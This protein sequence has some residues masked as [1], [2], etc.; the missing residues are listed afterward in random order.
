MMIYKNMVCNIPPV[1]RIFVVVLSLLL[2]LI[3]TN[4]SLAQPELHGRSSIDDT[5]VSIAD[6][7]DL[8][9]EQIADAAMNMA[10]EYP[11]EYNI[12]QVCEIYNSL[13]G[14]EGWYYFSDPSNADHYQNANKTLQMGKKQNTVGMGNCNDFSI[15]MASL[16]DSI[17]GSTR[18]IFAYDGQTGINHA[19]T[20]LYIGKAGDDSVNATLQFLEREYYPEKISGIEYVGDEVWLNL[21]WGTDPARA[22]NP[23]GA[24]FAEGNSD[25][26]KIVVWQSDSRARPGIVSVIEN[27]DSIE[28]WQTIADDLGSAIKIASEPGEKGNGIEV[29][30][31]LE[32]GGWVAIY[33]QIDPAA[34][35][36]SIGLMIS[37]FNID[38][39]DVLKLKL[40]YDD[41]TAFAVSWD[42][43]KIN[44]WGY[45]RAR[46]S[47]FRC[48]SDEGSGSSIDEAGEDQ[49]VNDSI[50][51]HSAIDLN[52]VRKL[53]ISISRNDGEVSGPGS[54]D[55]DEL[56]ELMAIPNG[57]P[58]LVAEE[59]QNR[60]DALELASES[61]RAYNKE[62]HSFWQ[63]MMHPLIQG[64]ALA[65]ESLSKCETLAG[66]QSLLRGIKSLPR[67]IARFKHNSS[68]SYVA[69][70][71]DGRRLASCDYDNT[72]RIWEIE[73]GR[74]L[75][76]IEHGSSVE[77]VAFSSDGRRL[78]TTTE[79]NT[80]F[81]WDAETGRR[82][83][84]A[85]YSGIRRID[86]SRDEE[87]FAAARGSTVVLWNSKTGGK[88]KQIDH[89]G[90]VRSVTFSSNG[91]RLATDCGN[92]ARIFDAVSGEE[93]GEFQIDS[94]SDNGIS[95][96]PEGSILAA[97]SGQQ[98]I[99]WDISS[100]EEIFRLQ[101]DSDVRYIVF[102]PDGRNLATASNDGAIRIWDA[103]T[104]KEIFK[105]Y[106][107][108]SIELLM[109]SSNGMKLAAADSNEIMVM[110]VKSGSGLARM[111][112]SCPIKCI[113]L[114]PDG[115]KLATGG[116]INIEDDFTARLWNVETGEEE[117]KMIQG[118]S[119]EHIAFSP[120]G[121]RIA[122][123]GMDQYVILWD[124]QV[125]EADENLKLNASIN[126]M[127][128][129]SDGE[130][131]AA[132][133]GDLGEDRGQI[134]L[135]DAHSYQVL[136]A[137]FFNN[138]ADVVSF[139]PGGDKIAISFDDETIGIFDIQTW[140]ELVRLT[141][142]GSVIS[143]RFSRDG[144]SLASASSNGAARIWDVE[145]GRMLFELKSGETVNSASFTP[146]CRKVAMDSS[147]NSAKIWDIETGK[148][149]LS[150]KCDGAVFSVE[151]S[152]DGKKLATGSDDFRARI[153]NAN[154][155]KEL[156]T[157]YHD[158]LVL[159]LCFSP[160]GSRLATGSMDA[161]VR[162]WNTQTGEMMSELQY[163]GMVTSAAFSP[164]GRWLAI[165]EWGDT[166]SI[167]P[168]SSTSLICEGCSR[169]ACNLTS[170]EWWDRYCWECEDSFSSKKI[171]KQSNPVES[172]G[173]YSNASI[174]SET[175]ATW[176]QTF[177]GPK[178][179]DGMSVQQTDD[180]GYIMAGLTHS[181]GKG[182]AWL[183][184]VDS[185]G[186]KIWDRVFGEST[187]DFA[188]SIEQTDDGGYIFAG[189]KNEGSDAWLGKIDSNGNM[190]W[191]R[192][193]ADCYGSSVQQTQ[194][195]GYVLAGTAQGKSAWLAK[196][197]GNGDLLWDSTFGDPDIMTE[198]NCVRQTDDGGYIL[199]GTKITH[200]EI[201][202]EVK[203]DKAI[204]LVKADENGDKTWSKTFGKYGDA[205]GRAVVQTFNGDYA[206]A[207]D[208]KY[209]DVQNSD[210]DIW[211]I[212][213]DE[214]GKMLWDMTYGG[215]DD[216][217]GYSL[218]QTA[219]NGYLIA[220]STE[221]FGSGGSDMWL[222]KTAEDGS[223]L[224]NRCFGGK[225][226]DFGEYVQ[227]TG[228]GACIMLG[229]TESYG[230]GNFDF[231]LV[232]TDVG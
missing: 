141:D 65:V 222:V 221:S 67:P 112:Y 20:E 140:D 168:T 160:D 229:Y 53:E 115:K 215:L 39:R 27:M 11:G 213:T 134:R 104:G 16:I 49:A 55:I 167:W 173:N 232:K 83:I 77:S 142:T 166:L 99:I 128:Y 105:K 129:S 125:E 214:T 202:S 183:V 163:V 37:Y 50:S 180:G 66:Q 179:E 110:D 46:Y 113:S 48:L 29:S 73:S 198:A 216:E 147:N 193:F 208:T 28:G 136:D 203:A 63:G 174:E 86:L 17:G 26:V 206:V 228:D 21:D 56:R 196:L 127:V 58:W 191:E 106:M 224:W 126:N 5:M 43:L 76:R 71:P 170:E 230:S 190:T 19:Y 132:T 121:S 85:P 123:A 150:V 149:L 91:K 135:W 35:R 31:D 38:N 194:D 9:N 225:R 130:K 62:V 158:D 34:L 189:R 89:S 145:A 44:E 195:G 88:I 148:E 212:K 156:A 204:W 219:D 187:F 172:N 57:S 153:W 36:E 151:F 95:L 14:S 201:N 217:E 164:D 24:I 207:G 165:K 138:R 90:R 64:T 94:N 111:E 18:I 144:K 96:G 146:D 137:D 161:S 12:N 69:F 79:N 8:G 159:S 120:D 101:H 178:Y 117:L 154:T 231:Y 186:Q 152:P 100:G 30:Y 169:L 157:I 15:L 54:I 59:R 102:S 131:L 139:G 211:L 80:A 60:L 143:M 13:A 22:A 97:A 1:C 184:K 4:V 199:A 133:I 81:L 200:D 84:M 108:N 72:T 47:D 10:A 197:D 185:S 61:E 118:D 74:E 6:K 93:L 171:S 87:R 33:K 42:Q 70:S 78:I 3:S 41:G 155:G 23:G 218:Q 188:S 109:Y 45:Q 7:L 116:G 98:A 209:D 114:S 181:F 82:L 75:L 226:F 51:D 205:T 177:G 119:V 68:V 182:G 103:R 32:E 92:L 107:E 25:V 2:L 223:E 40:I 192:S 210:S 220:G 176:T 227:K 122:S 175:V 162:I 52:R 124:T